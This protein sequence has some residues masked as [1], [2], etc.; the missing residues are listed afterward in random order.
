MQDSRQIVPACLR[1]VALLTVGMTL[2]FGCAT[3]QA[4]PDACA[5]PLSQ[6]I[7]NSCVVVPHTLWRGSKPDADGATALVSLGVRTV[8]NLELLHDD[9]DAFRA[10]QPTT[11]RSVRIDYFRIRDWEP[12]VVIAPALLDSHVADFLA[13]VKTEAKPIYVHCRAGQNR[14]GVMI[15]AYRVLVEGASSESAIAEMQRY[16]GVWFKHDAEYIRSL[17]GEHRL[18]IEKMVDSRIGRIRPE[19][20]VECSASGCNQDK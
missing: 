16:Q 3:P 1:T 4:L 7:T 18:K 13:I 15:A 19:A 20:H 11:A 5:S 10:A 9:L 2:L 8:V 6:A 17:T 14:T 12:N